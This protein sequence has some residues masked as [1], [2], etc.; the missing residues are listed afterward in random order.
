MA[1]PFT[2]NNPDTEYSSIEIEQRS[3]GTGGVEYAMNQPMTNIRSAI[4]KETVILCLFVSIRE[5]I[6]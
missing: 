5:I 2:Q 1:F 3:D 6:N 4:Y